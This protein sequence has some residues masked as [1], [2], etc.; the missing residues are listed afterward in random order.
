VTRL[1]VVACEEIH[2]QRGVFGCIGEDSKGAPWLSMVP[3]GRQ[4]SPGEEVEVSGER[5]LHYPTGLPQEQVLRILRHWVPWYLTQR[6]GLE[7]G[8]GVLVVGSGWLTEQVL[9]TCRLWGC[10]WRAV[11]GPPECQH[12]AEHWIPIDSSLDSAV[13]ARVLPSGPDAAIVLEA[14]ADQLRATMSVCRDR[15]TVVAAPP[16]EG[17]FEMN[18]YPDV[19]R[20]SLRLIAV[21]PF[22]YFVPDPEVW[23]KGTHRIAALLSQGLLAD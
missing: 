22:D 11:W 3:A 19:H 18:L 23:R 20:R 10:L 1:R 4:A 16:I 15:G 9:R 7:L 8:S 6:A 13:A 5:L 14:G 17:H 12:W 21:S 2:P